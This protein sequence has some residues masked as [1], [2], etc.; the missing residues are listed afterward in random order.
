MNYSSQSESEKTHSDNLNYSDS[1]QRFNGTVW[2]RTRV[3]NVRSPVRMTPGEGA[4][5]GKH[6]ADKCLTPVEALSSFITNEMLELIIHITE[7]NGKIVY[8]ENW[9]DVDYVK[10]KAFWGLSFLT[11]VYRQERTNFASLEL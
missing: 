6:I 9:I 5:P 4:A 3:L 1:F 8:S 11:N 7:V 2:S 10:L